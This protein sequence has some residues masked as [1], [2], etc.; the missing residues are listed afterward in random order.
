MNGTML[1]KLPVLVA[2]QPLFDINFL[3]SLGYGLPEKTISL[4]VLCAAFIRRPG[5]SN[6]HRHR[7]LRVPIHILFEWSLGDSFLVLREIH[8]RPV[9]DSNHQGSLDL[10]SNMLSLDQRAPVV[11]NS[12]I[13]DSFQLI[14]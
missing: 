3:W 8:V 12:T 4:P 11:P 5:I 9:Y 7:P 2:I 10:Q 13:V 6:M 1:L 14:N